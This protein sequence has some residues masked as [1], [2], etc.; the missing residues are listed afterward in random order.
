M[1]GRIY[2]QL[3]AFFFAF[4]PVIFNSKSKLPEFTYRN[5]WRVFEVFDSVISNRVEVINYWLSSGTNT[6]LWNMSTIKIPIGLFDG[7]MVK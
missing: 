4:N 7:L 3:L 6:Y 5:W 2:L 1:L